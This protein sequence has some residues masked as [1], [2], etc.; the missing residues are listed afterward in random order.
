MIIGYLNWHLHFR[1]QFDF[2]FMHLKFQI[3]LRWK[4]KKFAKSLPNV[5]RNHPLGMFE[6]LK[7]QLYLQLYNEW[8]KITSFTKYFFWCQFFM[9]CYAEIFVHDLVFNVSRFS[10]LCL[11]TRFI[12]E[13]KAIDVKSVYLSLGSD[14]VA[15][16]QVF[17]NYSETYIKGSFFSQGKKNC[18]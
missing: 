4:K 16:L 15:S 3:S 17:Y 8:Y 1:K 9:L 12:A 10:C 13:R 11:Q 5:F 2:T 6:K 14:K 7:I 18:G